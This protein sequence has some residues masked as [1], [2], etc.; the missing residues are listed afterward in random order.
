MGILAGLVRALP[1]LSELRVEMLT[2]SDTGV[3]LGS[4]GASSPV[5]RRS[6]GLLIRSSNNDL[7]LLYTELSLNKSLPSET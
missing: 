4:E 2:P 5:V 3:E 7:A 6:A 1:R